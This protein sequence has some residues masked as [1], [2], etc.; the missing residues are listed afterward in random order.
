MHLEEMN[1]NESNKKFGRRETMYYKPFIHTCLRHKVF[2]R[3][4][5][6]VVLDTKSKLSDWTRATPHEM[7]H[8]LV[9]VK[10]QFAHE[11]IIL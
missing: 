10:S 5:L 1:F 6:I 8:R 9:V 2:P 4:Q 11:K 7:N 3:I